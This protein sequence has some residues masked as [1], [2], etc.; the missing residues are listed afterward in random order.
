MC[1]IVSDDFGCRIVMNIFKTKLA[2]HVCLVYLFYCNLLRLL[3]ATKK[4]I[5]FQL[6]ISIYENMHLIFVSFDIWWMI[7]CQE[8]PYAFITRSGVV[9]IV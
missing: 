9:Y 7:K 4:E 1:R 3:K 2:V 8:G 5:I 6:T